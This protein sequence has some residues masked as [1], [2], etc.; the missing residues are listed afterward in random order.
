LKLRG[1]YTYNIPE[2]ISKGIDGVRL[3]R[4]SENPNQYRTYPERENIN[5]LIVRQGVV[6]DILRYYPNVEWLQ[7][8]NSGFEKVNLDVLRSRGILF[9]NAK[10]VYCATIAEDV[11]AKILILARNY[12]VHYANQIKSFWP[13]DSQL[14]NDN[15]DLCGKNI[16][17]LGAGYIG[18]E[19]AIRARAF[20]LHVYGYDPYVKKKEGF[21]KIYY[22]E[23]GLAQ[24]LATS[25]FVVT[26]LP[27]TN[28][29][30]N[31]I[32]HQTLSM[33]KSSA[34]LINVARGEIIDEDA[35]IGA[36]K[37]GQIRGAALDIVKSEPLP[38]SD[39]LWKTPN[40][41]ITPHRAAYG[42]QMENRMCALIERNIHHYL[43]GEEMENR[44]L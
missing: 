30:E 28:E 25:D 14:P 1:L 3:D 18:S 20:G 29:T 8:L 43:S 26:S 37:T 17:I 10:S 40:L 41:V 44:I 24:L 12:P 2:T 9:T 32:N 35:L 42:D 33:M 39:P 22:G 4:I 31:I 23:E 5:F 36:L 7:L 11:M 15:V 21:E 38:K 13:D 16:G 6:D 19:I 27:V 34:F